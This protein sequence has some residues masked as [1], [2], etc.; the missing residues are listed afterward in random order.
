MKG[1]YRFTDD[2]GTVA[3]FENIITTDGKTLIAKYLAGL[4][5]SYA[6]AIAVGAGTTAATSADKTLDYEFARVP[7]SVRNVT[8]PMSEIY[9]V[10]FKG[11]LPEGLTGVITESAVISQTFNASSGSFG[12]KVLATF[13]SGEG[14][15]T[16]SSSNMALSYIFQGYPVPATP[17]TDAV[18]IGPEAIL[19][20]SSGT[21]TITIESPVVQGDFSG[22][23]S[24]DIFA[25]AYSSNYISSGTTAT[26][27]LY[28]DASSYYSAAFPLTTQTDSV[29]AHR[30]SKILKSA[31]A[32]TGTPSWN[33]I[34]KVALIVASNNAST[35]VVLDAISVFDADY[36]TTDY[37]MISRALA[38]AP[39]VKT[40]GK[41]MD[42]EYFLEF[43]L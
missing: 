4:I 32:A 34:I 24:S 29:W 28:S 31:F 8:G 13:N 26:L 37:A 17:S 41:T 38:P 30:S 14:W 20:D 3:E 27:R 5:S 6:G 9:Q 1:F 7:I 19:L 42:V 10:S 35:N 18:R 25:L 40:A 39:V 15:T 23:S 11:T 21:S 33:N 36:I 2:S 16:I 43:K 12:D 22:Y